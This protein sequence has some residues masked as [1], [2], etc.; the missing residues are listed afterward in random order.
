VSGHVLPKQKLS[1][2]MASQ[3][4]SPRRLSVRHRLIVADLRENLTLPLLNAL[5]LAFAVAIMLTLSEVTLMPPRHRM[6]IILLLRWTIAAMVWFALLVAFIV[7]AINR[8]SQVR[9]RTRE[10]AIVRMLGASFSFIAMLLAEE[11]LLI[12]LPSIIIGIALAS[13]VGWSTATAMPDLFTY[14]TNVAAWIWSG[15]LVVACFYCVGIL[16]AWVTTRQQDVM[17]AL[18]YG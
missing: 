5:G 2:T 17:T 9:D 4:N 3:T 8:V 11:T 14:E 12:A 6:P 1:I 15:F 7:M 10:F 18:S 16:T 13:L